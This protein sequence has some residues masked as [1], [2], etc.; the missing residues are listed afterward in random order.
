[1]DAATLHLASTEGDTVSEPGR[2]KL[3]FT[4]GVEEALGAA[5]EL[6]GEQVLVERFVGRD[7]E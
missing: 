6:T 7:D 1:M 5:L 3:S 2:Y 4:N